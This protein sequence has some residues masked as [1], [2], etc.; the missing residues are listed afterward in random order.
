MKKN[1]S[2]KIIN[3]KNK[4]EN[5]EE[6]YIKQTL[7]IET[8][9]MT[10]RRKHFEI[11]KKEKIKIYLINSDKLKNI[12][13]NIVKKEEN[14]NIKSK[15]ISNI[16]IIGNNKE[17]ILGNKNIKKHIEDNK[18]DDIKKNSN[19]KYKIKNGYKKKF[20]ISKEFNKSQKKKWLNNDNKYLKCC[21]NLKNGKYF[22]FSKNNFHRI[23]QRK[24]DDIYDYLIIPKESEKNNDI[25]YKDYLEFK[26]DKQ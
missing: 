10:S 15:E 25:L 4:S 21:N 20:N 14:N 6:D 17:K 7:S 19:V 3:I 2:Y 12:D 9:K 23:K 5:E 18:E 26:P 16:E 22:Y 13:N 11:D 8:E 1:K 24:N